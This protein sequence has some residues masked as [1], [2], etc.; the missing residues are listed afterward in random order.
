MS[1]KFPLPR[2]LASG[3]RLHKVGLMKTLLLVLVAMAPLPLLAADS[4]PKPM[5]GTSSVSFAMDKDKNKSIKYHNL[6]YLFADPVYLTM[7]HDTKPSSFLIS[8]DVTAVAD[9]ESDSPP[10]SKIK[11]QAWTGV[12]DFPRK[13]VWTVECRG[14]SGKIGE[15]FYEVTHNGF[16]DDFNS[17]LY[18]RLTD[19][20]K[21]FESNIPLLSV[22]T[23]DE[24][25]QIRNIAMRSQFDDNELSK[26]VAAKKVAGIVYYGAET[27]PVKKIGI[28][29]W[30]EDDK[31][32]QPSGWLTY[33]KERVE[34]QWLFLDSS[35]ETGAKA[36]GGFSAVI[37]F[38][39][40]HVV[41]IPFENDAPQLS[42]AILPKGFS[43]ALI[44]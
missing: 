38:D 42:R 18:F 3:R 44:P 32:L 26:S 28:F 25:Y 34:P 27:G 41:E 15:R 17:Y 24:P 16:E 5:Q 22:H 7:G 9:F 21:A 2:C 20:K 1:K 14:D 4:L 19:G 11:A 36:M 35:K 13:L 43:V 23:N 40:E 37:Y 10:D 29:G 8:Q 39:A 33:K 31:P 6:T 12:Q 30:P